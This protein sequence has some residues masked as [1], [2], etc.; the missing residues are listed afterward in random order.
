M[1]KYL[2]TG[3]FIVM[4]IAVLGVYLGTFEAK[5]EEVS[6]HPADINEDWQ[7]V[8]SEAIAYLAG[9]QSGSNPMAY[10]IRAAYLWQNGEIYHYDAAQDPPLCWA[11]GALEPLKGTVVYENPVQLYAGG[12]PI[13]LGVH[14]AIRLVDWDYNGN[15]DLLVGAGDGYI[16]LF[17]NESKS[18]TPVFE[19]GTK[20]QANGLDL[21]AGTEYTGVSFVDVTGDGLRD[22]IIGCCNNQIRLYINSGIPTSPAFTVPVPLPGPSGDLILPD[23][24]GGRIDV[25]DWDGDGLQDIFAGG[26]DGKLRFYRNDG[27][28]TSPH[29]EEGVLFTLN[30]WTIEWPYNIHPKVFDVNQ[31]GLPDL[32]YGYNWGDIG[33]FV[34]E[35]SLGLTEF[36]SHCRVTDSSGTQLNIRSLNGDDTIPEFI[37]M[38]NDGV[39]DL[40]SGGLNGK[41]FVMNGISYTSRLD[42]IQEIMDAHPSDLG[43]AL[44]EDAN[45]RTELFGLHRAVRAMVAD[46]FK[47]PTDRQFMADWYAAHV[48]AYPQYLYKQH[49]DPA[50]QPYVGVLAGQVWINL[51]ECLPDSTQHRNNLANAIGLPVI[52]QNILVDF[53]TLFNE[54][55][56]ADEEQQNVVYN[57]LAALPRPLWDAENISI[58]DYFGSNLPS[59][60]R[61]EARTGVNIFGIRVGQWTENSFPPDSKPGIVDTYSICLAHEINHTVDAHTISPNRVL[62][63]R[64]YTLIEQAAPPDIVFLDHAI[65]FGVDWNATKAQF[66]SQ[67]YWDGIDG[68]WQN[69]WNN[70][71][72]SGPGHNYNDHWLRNN[73]K[74]M[75]EAPQESFATL[76]NQYFTDSAIM[77]DLCCRRW[78]R[79]IT[80]CINQFLYF[81]DIYSL[82]SSTTYFYQIDTQGNLSRTTV[83]L[84]RDTYGH[85]ESLDIN[86]MTYEFTLDAEGN[87]L[88]I[89]KPESEGEE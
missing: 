82:G 45:L 22:L 57:Y 17:R 20:V 26:F 89:V 25:A 3:V 13:N 14:A 66:Q 60:V 37:D 62:Q 10:A 48:D 34:R 59:E 61:M 75:C 15:L 54:N 46:F 69:A 71:W 8:M 70:F 72:I 67:G 52:H 32:A 43:P 28:V 51:L 65:G 27:S 5:A 76:A 49:L 78:D 87:V 38:N 64:R 21:R 77:L 42:R 74:L 44:L 63:E 24:C 23:W 53:G 79:G 56:T 2:Q 4:A 80:C 6:I 33:F 83:P 68:N 58:I 40:L 86:G 50:V 84:T 35:N 47:A 16:W 31:D 1:K 11:L 18:T 81:A 73:L 39:L 36:H 88:E 85:I 7:L 41:I 55:S 30:G 9:W 12:N 19:S 29:F